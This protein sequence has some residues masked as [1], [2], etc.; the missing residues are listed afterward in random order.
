[1]RTA[2]LLALLAGVLPQDRGS[3]GAAIVIGGGGDQPAI[4]KKLIELSGGPDAR[5]LVMPIST[6]QKD[7]GQAMAAF[8]REQGAK[9]VG[10]WIP[11]SQEDADTPES[12]AE[13]KAARGFYFSGGDQTRG[14]ALLRKTKALEAIREAHGRGAAVAGSSAGA[15]LMSKEMIDG[16]PPEGSISPGRYATS[17]G[18]G[19]TGNWITDQHFLARSR[20]QRLINVLLDHP[21][22]R[23]LGVD[24][25]TAAVFVD[26]TLEVLGQGQVVLFD[27]PA[28]VSSRPTESRPLYRADDI[29]MRVLATGDK[30]KLERGR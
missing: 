18:L 30:I 2:I 17:E 9:N 22:H 29:R 28:G 16:A 4:V 8:I 11:K 26:D 13:L 10:I 21:G 20:M 24:E 14:M 19:V 7:P 15:A 6:S 3:P 12:L 23:G 1:M 5:I 25:R 27:P